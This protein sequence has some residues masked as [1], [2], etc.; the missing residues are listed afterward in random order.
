MSLAFTCLIL[1]NITMS[2]T[3]KILELKFDYNKTLSTF[4]D[5]L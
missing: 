1:Q 2:N 3:D 5:I 4:Q